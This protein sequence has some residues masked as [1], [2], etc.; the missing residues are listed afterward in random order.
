VRS[1]HIDGYA[2]WAV[3]SKW[4]H[5]CL[6]YGWREMVAGEQAGL[7]LEGRLITRYTV[8]VRYYCAAF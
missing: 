3:V 6:Q 5:I 1:W 7:Q 2:F 8:Q 4:T